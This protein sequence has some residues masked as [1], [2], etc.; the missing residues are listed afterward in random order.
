MLSIFCKLLI[1]EGTDYFFEPDFTLLDD[2]M[3]LGTLFTRD[4]TVPF[5][6]SP[7]VKIYSPPV[8][9]VDFTLGSIED[10]RS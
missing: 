9:Q 6:E 10:R 1:A 5:V 4:R 3:K 8:A 2:N 7:D